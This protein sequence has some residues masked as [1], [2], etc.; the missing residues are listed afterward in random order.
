MDLNKAQPNWIRET[1]H[2]RSLQRVPVMWGVESTEKLL[3]VKKFT[4]VKP[5]YLWIALIVVIVYVIILL[6]VLFCVLLVWMYST[7]VLCISF[8]F[9][10]SISCVC[11]CARYGWK[12]EPD[13]VLAASTPVLSSWDKWT[14]PGMLFCVHPL[15]T[16][17]SQT[18]IH[19]SLTIASLSA[20][21]QNSSFLSFLATGIS[22]DSNVFWV[23]VT[24][25]Y[26]FMLFCYMENLALE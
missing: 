26:C 13:Q 25:K 21:T 22:K 3:L 4:V 12:W 8:I 23:W 7:W 15:Y 19:H 16:R 17:W 6:Y 5:V 24:L 14:Y 10:L 20:N 18:Q 9:T 2:L 11:F 1:C